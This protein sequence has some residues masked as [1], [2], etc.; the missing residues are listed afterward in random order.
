M[1]T[2]VSGYATAFFCFFLVIAVLG[3][4]WSRILRFGVNN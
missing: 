4:E 2:I 3:W 1:G